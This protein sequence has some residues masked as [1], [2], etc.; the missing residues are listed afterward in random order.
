LAHD[1]EGVP[2]AEAK[3]APLVHIRHSNQASYVMAA[4]DA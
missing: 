2:D 3:T 4:S 1:S